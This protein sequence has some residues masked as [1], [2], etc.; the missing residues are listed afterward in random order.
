VS[1]GPI[2]Y[3]DGY[4]LPRLNSVHVRHADASA[5][6]VLKGSDDIRV[7]IP[8]LFGCMEM[9]W[10]EDMPYVGEERIE[11]TIVLVQD[12]PRLMEASESLFGMHDG[13]CC[14]SV[15][16]GPSIFHV[17]S[18]L[19]DIGKDVIGIVWR[20]HY[21]E[22]RL[23]QG[24]PLLSV[25]E[26]IRFYDPHMLFGRPTICV[27]TRGLKDWG[28]VPGTP[29]VRLDDRYPNICKDFI[30][31]MGSD[32]EIVEAGDADLTLAMVR[33]DDIIDQGLYPLDRILDDD[34]LVLR[35]HGQV[36]TDHGP[37][38]DLLFQGLGDACD[39]DMF[40][41]AVEEIVD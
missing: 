40:D 34:L 39:L 19:A 7:V 38:P 11:R 24:A 20:S 8:N 37:V 10:T 36:Q 12:D 5:Q 26:R 31:S 18:T 4:V 17:L 23:G 3:D 30:R 16:E 14:L 29:R 33:S 25:M 22:S 6:H 1:L 35:S 15:V 28:S 27:L 21:K 32:L 41:L 2:G 13:S 9:I